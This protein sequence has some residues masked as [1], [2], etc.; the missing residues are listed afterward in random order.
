[1]NRPGA[2]I[3]MRERNEKAEIS[4]TTPDWSRE[5]SSGYWD[6]GRRLLEAIRSY[7]HWAA[8]GGVLAEVM[9]REAVIRHHFWSVIA[10]ADIPLTCRLGGGFVMMHPNGIVIHPEAEIG[11]NCL[12]LQ[13]VTITG[14]VKIG[15]HVDIG[16]GA[17]IIGPVEIGDHAVIGANAVI[18]KDVPAGCT[19]GGVPGRILRG[20]GG[21]MPNGVE[22]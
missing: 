16:A 21:E 14:R 4:A 20:P 3:F 2:E 7:Q 11:P 22:E 9:M 15:G 8:R 5:I 1:M 17:K 10:G 12:V 13:Q 19:V 6:P 18:T